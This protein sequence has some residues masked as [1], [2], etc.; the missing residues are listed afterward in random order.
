[1]PIRLVFCGTPPFALPSLNH[2]LVDSR[3]DVAAVV[4]QP[5]RPRGRGHEISRPPVKEIA[6]AKGLRVFQPEKIRD[7]SSHEFFASISPDVVVIIAYG[8]IV[9]ATL[10]KMPRLGWINLHASL[11]PKYRGAAPINWAIINGERFTGNSTLQVDAGMDTGAILLQQRLEIG[12]EETAPQL[13]ARLAE[14]G[15]PLIINSI[16]GLDQ[17]SL[18]PHPQ[19]SALACR[20]PL[21]KKD[22]GRV[23]WRLS[24]A[25]IYNR[26]R[27][28]DPWPGAFTY[29]RGHSCRICGAPAHIPIE[30]Q[31]H[32][33]GTILSSGNLLLVVCGENTLFELTELQLEGRKRVSAS[34]F[35][36]G[37]H[38]T[39]GESFSSEATSATKSTPR[40]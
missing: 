13:A 17:R 14:A 2:L 18:T 7:Q 25:Q 20:A 29:F 23:D 33:S 39:Q 8:Q 3:F 24:A 32:S 16:I 31:S 1:M 4:T 38:L 6:L 12:P 11:L 28:L 5:D 26:L 40:D 22:D 10:L 36:R 15:A 19:D 35:Q 9:P 37:A 27:G 30:V 21:L 34:E